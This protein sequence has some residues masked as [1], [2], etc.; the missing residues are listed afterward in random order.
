MAEIRPFVRSLEQVA[1]PNQEHNV[2]ASVLGAY[3]AAMRRSKNE[4]SAFAAGVQTYLLY[5]PNVPEP[6]ARVAVARIISS[7]NSGTHQRRN[8]G[9]LCPL[10]VE[11]SRLRSFVG[12]AAHGA[13][14]S[15]STRQVSAGP[16]P[17]ADLLPVQKLTALCC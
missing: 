9:K 16:A 4:W 14:L 1:A 11:P 12:M 3:T 7:K 8:R 17:K 10:W 6:A 5:H 13:S 15:S 2:A